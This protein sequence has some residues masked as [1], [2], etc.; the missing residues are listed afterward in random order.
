VRDELPIAGSVQGLI[1]DRLGSL[2]AN[3]AAVVEVAAVCGDRLSLE[4]LAATARLQSI[5]LVDSVDA[6]VRRGILREVE[7][8]LEFGHGQ[9]R[10]VAYERLP[11]SDAAR[12]HLD[13]A[14][15]LERL[16]AGTAAE[17]AHH[18]TR[19]GGWSKAFD[20]HRE[21]AGAAAALLAY[22]AAAEHFGMAAG[23]SGK[24]RASPAAEFDLL[25]AFD[26]VLDVLGRN[27]VQPGVLERMAR[28]AFPDPAQSLDVKLRQARAEGASGRLE[29]AIGICREALDLARSG[30]SA[31][32]VIRSLTSLGTYLVWAGKAREAIGPLREASGSPGGRIDLRAEAGHRLATA[33]ADTQSYAEA[34]SALAEAMADYEAL[35]DLRGK[36]GV[37]GTS[38]IVA[39]ETGHVD[40][41]EL[42]YEQAIELCHRIGYRRGEGV[43][44]VNLASLRYLS[45]HAGDALSLYDEAAVIFH[46]VDERRGEATVLANSASVRANIVGDVERAAEDASRALSYF[47]EIDDLRSQAQCLGILAAVKRSEGDLEAAHRTLAAAID[48]ADQSGHRWLAVQ[49]DRSRARLL[50]D[51]GD[52][53]QAL[54][55]AEAA[56]IECEHLGM[57]DLRVSLLALQAESLLA[58]G[59]IEASR[60]RAEEALSGLGRGV[61][62]PY[63]VWFAW[64]A[65]LDE[66]GDR[67]GSQR[68]LAEAHERMMDV[69][70]NLPPELR[71]TALRRV[72]EHRQI[73]EAWEAVQPSVVRMRLA[74][75]GAP[76]GRKLAE[77]DLVDVEVVLSVRPNRGWSTDATTR[78]RAI[79]LLVTDSL[80]QG[81][82][83][84]VE[85]LSVALRVSNSTV[86]RDLARLR[87]EGEVLPTRGR[88]AGI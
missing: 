45:G 5:D 64:S 24:A 38:A 82:S 63:T 41:A 50:L 73:V 69:I 86:R 35:G 42:L 70:G 28:L 78:K 13:V 11:H 61:E 8:R 85:D 46:Q 7:E 72:P 18:F 84:T 12:I 14:E 4:V 17:R 80:R 56:A 88:A 65:V 10:R 39:A 23:M 30:S 20:Y 51:V 52:A 6:L 25:G 44:L 1:A 19:A 79:G 87:A 75:V 9:I 47:N 58:L 16:E 59:R 62:R 48:R 77:S 57:A 40:E 26:D 76:A 53:D 49:L 54:D 31:D 15:T 37:M 3:A 34:R 67:E 2:P 66:T 21:A 83:P 22:E 27:E 33:L 43:N 71:D 74:K 55:V 60:H 32:H 68:A 29:S 81:A 36:A